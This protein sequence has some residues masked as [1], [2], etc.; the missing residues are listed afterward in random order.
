M[1]VEGETM[2]CEEED[3]WEEEEDIDPWFDDE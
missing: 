3:Y 1:L 2:H